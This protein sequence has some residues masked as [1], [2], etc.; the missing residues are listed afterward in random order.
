MDRLVPRVFT[1][2][3][4]EVFPH[5]SL[6]LL[7]MWSSFFRC[8]SVGRCSPQWSSQVEGLSCAFV[9]ALIPTEWYQ[10]LKF[11]LFQLVFN[12]THLLICL[13]LKMEANTSRMISLNGTNYQAWKGKMEDLLYVKEYWKPVFAEAKP[14]D[15][16]DD[17]WRV[18]HR[19]A[20]DFIWQWVD[21]N[22]LNHIS[23]ETHA[24]TLWQKLEECNTRIFKLG[25]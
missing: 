18:L 7:C 10:E 8:I 4:E 2:H 24:H 12:L 5:K 17:D 21:D 15:K 19:Q 20:C 3:L 11:R 22:V 14:D 25:A 9:S 13:V 16:S 23:D 1:P 6:C